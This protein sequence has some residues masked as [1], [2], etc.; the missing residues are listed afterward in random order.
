MRTSLAMSLWM[1]SGISQGQYVALLGLLRVVSGGQLEQNPEMMRA[2]HH[3]DLPVNNQN[4]EDEVGANIET[5]EN[6]A[7]QD[8]PDE[9]DDE[10]HEEEVVQDTTFGGSTEIAILAS[11]NEHLNRKFLDR[12]AEF[13]S[14]FFGGPHVTCAAMVQQGE[15]A[16]ILLSKNSE[17]DQASKEYFET[18]FASRL[19]NIAKAS[20]SESDPTQNLER[21]LWSFML[22]YRTDRA[23]KKYMP[24]FQKAMACWQK[25]PHS[26]SLD[27]DDTE[28]YSA[29]ALLLSMIQDF[30]VPAVDC[31]ITFVGAR[32]ESMD[33]IVR[34]AYDIRVSKSARKYLQHPKASQVWRWFCFVG[35]LRTA[36][37][38]FLAAARLHCNFENIKIKYIYMITT[39]SDPH[40]SPLSFVDT[41][42]AFYYL[43]HIP[44]ENLM[45]KKRLFEEYHE[46][47]RYIH[48]EIQL[49]KALSG[50]NAAFPYICGSK[51]GCFACSSFVKSYGRFGVRVAI[52]QSTINEQCRMYHRHNPRNGI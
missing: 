35:R 47:Q 16:T 4:T 9:E 10:L 20:Q 25:T 2:Q 39:H 14:P 49:W 37:E 17:W 6:G 5:D 42:S 29:L 26:K 30:L 24:E 33:S 45:K 21:D 34:S 3:S 46:S 36:F 1:Q 12:L 27:V 38:A 22:T 11:S 8:E 40:H 28:T 32:M 31:D 15:D 7:V 50:Y 18:H 51:K 13:A 23:R 52:S 41:W 43:I 19:S 44:K 48:A